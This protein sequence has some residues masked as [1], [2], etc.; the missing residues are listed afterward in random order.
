MTLT[1]PRWALAEQSSFIDYLTATAGIARIVRTLADD[2][3]R[4]ESPCG[5][6]DFV[7]LLLGIAGLGA[8]IERLADPPAAPA[9]PAGGPPERPTRWLR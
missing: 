1:D 5:D 7:H 2:Q 4:L 8:D 3:R 9:A 6:N